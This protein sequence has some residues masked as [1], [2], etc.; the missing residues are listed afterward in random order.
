MIISKKNNAMERMFSSKDL[1]L[2]LWPLIIEQL[3]AISLGM[4][5][6][7]MVGSLGEAAMSGVSLVD[8]VFVLINQI[9]AAMATGGAVVASQYIGRKDSS[10]ASATAKQLI[11]SVTALAS[12]CMVL[13][14]FIRDFLLASMF[15]KIDADVM[16]A[17]QKYFL[18]TLFS[19]PS[20]ALYNSCAALFRAQGNSKVSM[21]IAL[22][23]NVLN[24]GGNALLLYGFGFG[25]EGVAIPTFF[26]RTIAAIVLLYMLRRDTGSISSSKTHM[27][28]INIRGLL[29]TRLDFSLIKRIL[30]VGIPAG[31]ENSVFQIG[32]ILMITLIA[33]YGT[34]AIAANAAANTIAGFQVLPGAAVGMALLTVVGQCI[35]AD[36]HEEAIYYIKKLLAFAYGIM[37]FLNISILLGGTTLLGFYGLS[38]EA[39]K[40]GWQ[41][42]MLHGV[43]GILIWPL[44]FSLPNAFR[45]ANDG[46]FTL[47]VSLISM[48]TLR[49]GGS[50][51]L[52]AVTNLG[53]VSVWVAMVVDWVLRS[54]L[55][56]ARFKSRKWLR[57]KLI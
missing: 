18:Y 6:I 26:A 2:L 32:K 40:M 55:F 37:F 46:K 8:A 41:M 17:A 36:R 15:G 16:A 35:G 21:Y 28:V 19:M 56:T 44:S 50:Y 1:W 5:D 13:G 22:L 39:I 49:V 27:N 52:A 42:I 57:K 48:W 7:I 30:Q 23:V 20:I 24:I 51:F 14:F 29:K 31:L 45:A 53:A 54:A 43:F 25:V 10:N 4:A 38:D 34:S 9:F 33:S 11:I 47:I 12:I 3:L